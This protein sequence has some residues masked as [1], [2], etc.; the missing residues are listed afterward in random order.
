MK[1]ISVAL[2]G[3]GFD[4]FEGDTVFVK[5]EKADYYCNAISRKRF[6]QK[7]IMLNTGLK[8]NAS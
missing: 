4:S 8:L 6:Q 2:F 7:L 5:E 1:K 3:A